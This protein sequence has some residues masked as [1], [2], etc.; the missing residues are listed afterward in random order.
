MS[1]FTYFHTTALI[2]I[3]I[4]ILSELVVREL[5]YLLTKE[6]LY[7]TAE[8]SLLKGQL[9]NFSYRHGVGNR[10]FS[11]KSDTLPVTEKEQM[12]LDAIEQYWVMRKRVQEIDDNL[13]FLKIF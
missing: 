13:N 2:L 5:T 4:F 9:N 11:S 3:T 12:Y 7:L 6:K 10:I 8:V 1:G